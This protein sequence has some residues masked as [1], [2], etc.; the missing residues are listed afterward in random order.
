LEA[1]DDSH[2]AVLDDNGKLR[3]E[4]AEALRSGINEV[5]NQ[6]EG[7][8]AGLAELP[9]K[10]NLSGYR[11]AAAAVTFRAHRWGVLA[12]AVPKNASPETLALVCLLLTT[13]GQQ[14]AARLDAELQERR[15]QVLQKELEGQSWLANTGEMAG[16]L[17]HEFNNFLNIVLLHVALMEAQTPEKLR[18]ELT[19][20][21][22]QAATVTSAVK[23][24][25]QY[26]RRRQSV[27]GL[28]EIN[29]LVSD[30]VR[31]L[32]AAPSE[33]NEQLL[34]KLPPSSRIE[35]AGLGR[36]VAVPLKVVLVANL[37]RVLGSAADLKRLCVFLLTNAA[38]AAGSI[39]GS[40]AI[41]TESSNGNVLLRVEDDGPSVPSELLPHFFEPSTV[42]R[43]GT[44]SLELAACETLVRR[45]QGKIRVESRGER[46][47]VVIVE[48]PIA[49]TGSGG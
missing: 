7:T 24:I 28:V 26:R 34:I 30:T 12:L 3:A 2:F 36:P 4:W 1:Q 29:E 6:V 48:L 22:R 37:P 38:V 18:S 43:G 47:V 32:T 44:N 19:E 13:G 15:L 16:P 39:G 5:C 42:G 21:R 9:A 35:T 45:L 49:R 23:Q 17:A 11:L 20:L 31:A 41:R 8:P 10:L 46:G 14:L 25:Q 40:V 27:Q 33:P